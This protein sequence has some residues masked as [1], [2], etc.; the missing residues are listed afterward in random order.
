VRIT[1]DGRIHLHSG[2]GNLGTYSYASTTR[3]AAEVLKC[4]WESC[5]IHHGNSSLHLPWSSYQAGSNTS[6]T[7]SRANYVAAQDLLAK[8]KEIA[9]TTLGGNPGDYDVAD[10]R[11]F[12]STEPDVSMSYADAAARAIELG[13]RFSGAVYPDDIHEVTRRAVEGLA[14]T[15]LIGVAKDTLPKRG[16]APGLAVAFCEIELDL[17]TGKHEIV[18]YLA[19]AECGTVVHPLGLAGQ[20]RGGA[21]WGFGMATLE[22]HV[23]D[24]QNGLPAH[25]GYY[26][27]RPP[28]YLDVPAHMNTAAV[29]KADPDNPIGARGIGEPAMGCATAAVM[30]AISDALG[31]HLFSRTPVTPDMIITHLAGLD[32]STPV[33]A[34][35]TF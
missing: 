2:V 5:V 14:G 28:T 34:I 29:D 17:E 8:M 32:S 1:P 3:A 25:V 33:M 26:Q 4:R 16:T 13:G 20:L 24:P 22:R 35:N 21:V 7:H 18:D 12:R 23:Y 31:G 6:F 11:I 27:T 19:V 15:G 10:E 30:C 9:A